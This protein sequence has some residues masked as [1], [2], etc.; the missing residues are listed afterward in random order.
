[1]RRPKSDIPVAAIEKKVSDF[2]RFRGFIYFSKYECL[3]G[4]AVVGIREYYENGTIARE[5]PIKD[6]QIHGRVYDWEED[7]KLLS[8][9]PWFHGKPHGIAKQYS[10]NRILGT[11]KLLH[12]TGYDLWRSRGSDGTVYLSEIHSMKD[13]LPHGFTWWINRNKTIWNESHW[14]EG[15]LHGIER[16]WNNYGDLCGR[17]NRGYPKYWIKNRQVTR[18]RYLIECRKDSTLPAYRTSDDLPR[19]IFPAP[20]ARL[21][22]DRRKVKIAKNCISCRAC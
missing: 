7:G 5:T 12:G 17:L 8:M 1:M 11:Y 4:D 2:R 15:K 14:H 13:G 16:R 19:R 10:S 22:K 20:L 9:E 21:I 18:R 6:G 3:I